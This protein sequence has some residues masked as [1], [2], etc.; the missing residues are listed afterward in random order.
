[1]SAP[2][3]VDLLA[4]AARDLC[5][6]EARLKESEARFHSLVSLSFDSYWEQDESLSFTEFSGPLLNQLGITA[7]FLLRRTGWEIPGA[8]WNEEAQRRAGTEPGGARAVS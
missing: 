4:L 1:M 5:I 6:S 7:D 3:Y 8:R 2:G